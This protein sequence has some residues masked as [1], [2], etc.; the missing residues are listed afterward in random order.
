MEFSLA[1]PMEFI[2]ALRGCPDPGKIIDFLGSKMKPDR[3]QNDTYVG[4]NLKLSLVSNCY[5]NNNNPNNNNI[6]TTKEG[7]DAVVAV[8]DFKKIKEKGE[9]RMIVISKRMV[10]LDFKE[11]F[12]EKILKEYS[13]K[14][15]EEKL[16]LL[17]EKRNIKSPAGWLMAALKNDYQDVGEERYEEEPAGGSGNLV[18][19]PEQASRQ[20]ALEAIRLIQDN[21]S[22]CISP[23][24]SGKRTGVR[25]NVN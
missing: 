14:K 25:E 24:P 4:S 7:K 11:E 2:I 13:A 19:T 1:L 8:V 10:E 12:V 5:P 23:L 6:T 18:N 16:D 15:I 9:E 17:M 21:L 22:N 20:K 3:Y